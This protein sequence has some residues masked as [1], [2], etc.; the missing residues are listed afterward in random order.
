MLCLDA[1]LP[2]DTTGNDD[3]DV[4]FLEE[5]DQGWGVL[6]LLAGLGGVILR[7]RE[8]MEGAGENLSMYL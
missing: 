8:G 6:V 3:D 2:T 5:R 4:F 7:C 1:A